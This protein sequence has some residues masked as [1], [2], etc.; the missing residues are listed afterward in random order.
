M[1]I[2]ARRPWV[3]AA[4]SGGLPPCRRRRRRRRC[5]RPPAIHPRSPLAVAALSTTLSTAALDKHPQSKERGITL[6]LGFSSF[7]VRGSCSCW[8]NVPIPSRQLRRPPTCAALG[9]CCMSRRATL[10]CTN[11]AAALPLPLPPQV[12]APPH[13]AA[14]GYSHIQFTLVD[15]PGH[16]SLIR[17]IIG[18]AQV[19]QHSWGSCAGACHPAA[20]APATEGLQA[21]GCSAHC[22]LPSSSRCRGALAVSC[23]LCA[24]PLPC[25][26]TWWLCVVLCVPTAFM[27]QI[28][29]MFFMIEIQLM[30]RRS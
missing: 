5:L 13:I 16:A 23:S 28:H 8:A 1:W 19:R 17:T 18:G 24:R 30:F 22:P 14:G 12:P 4:L 6:D 29:L 3:S 27:I 26:A 10:R 9:A 15:C 20:A 11:P 2:A 7:T 25:L 21:C